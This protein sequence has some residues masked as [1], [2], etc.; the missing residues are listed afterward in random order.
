MWG[1]PRVLAPVLLALT[2][3]LSGCVASSPSPNPSATSSP[4]AED[5]P[6]FD[7]E[8]EALAAA[9]AAYAEYQAAVDANLAE[10]GRE[11][12]P[13]DQHS[14]GEATELARASFAEFQEK[15][16]RSVGTTVIEAISL[17]DW[18][19]E[20]GESPA[21]LAYICLNVGAVDVVDADG[22]S[23][24]SADRP[25]LQAFDVGFDLRDGDLLLSSRSPRDA[26]GVCT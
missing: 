24:V 8:E 26:E 17:A 6:L 21:V 2:L 4:S 14:V 11:V 13:I 12:R 15:H 1:M 7:S 23:V 10:G 16:W 19:A 9:E 22:N 20:P 5:E 3:M 25:D 18:S